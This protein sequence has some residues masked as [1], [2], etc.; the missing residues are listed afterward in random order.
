MQQ[1][2][3]KNL[4]GWLQAIH[5]EAQGAHSSVRDMKAKVDLLPEIDRSSREGSKDSNDG[6]RKIEDLKNHLEAKINRMEDTLNDL[7]STMKDI[8]NKVN[9]LK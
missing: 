4:M 1:E 6:E 8:Q 7:R 2:D 5:K 9:H 3:L